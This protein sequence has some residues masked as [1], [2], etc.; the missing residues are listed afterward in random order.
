MSPLAF[1]VFEIVYTTRV[2]EEIFEL[3]IRP[4]D[5]QPLAP[6]LAGQWVGI[7][8]LNESDPTRKIAAF[9]IACAP[10]ERKDVLV[11][12]IKAYGERTAALVQ[13][14]PGDQIHVQGPYGAFV[15]KPGNSRLV[16]FAGGVGVTPLRSMIR[17]SLFS[18][19]TREIVLFYSNKT[20]ASTAYEQEF[21]DLAK[22]Y[23]NF[24]FVPTL[25]GEK[26]S[27]WKGE[28]RRIDADMIRAY[29]GDIRADDDFYMCGPDSF[30]DGIKQELIHFGVD[31]KAHLKKELFH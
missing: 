27:E 12:A 5:G 28:Q 10:S 30:M 11:L 9:S 18:G 25:T 8:L 22:T 15:H 1:R 23:T 13:M 20:R 7:R 19:E 2:A 26:L 17:Q 4:T 24:T 6:F 31:V 29:V 14:K 21:R 3:G 16:F